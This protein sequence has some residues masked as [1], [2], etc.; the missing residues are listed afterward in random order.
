MPNQPK[1]P[2]RTCRIRDE[3]WELLGQLAAAQGHTRGDVI[4]DLVRWYIGES[5]VLPPRPTDRRRRP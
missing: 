2:A 5:D 4:R 1:T 3:E